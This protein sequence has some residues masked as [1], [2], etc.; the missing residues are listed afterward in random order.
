MMGVIDRLEQHSEELPH[1]HHAPVDTMRL[2][3]AQNI[4]VREAADQAQSCDPRMGP[5]LI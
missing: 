4:C 3:E 2:V 1:R 5:G